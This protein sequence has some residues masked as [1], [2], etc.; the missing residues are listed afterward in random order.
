[1]RR[2]I[3]VILSLMTLMSWACHEKIIVHPPPRMPEASSPQTAAV[4]PSKPSIPSSLDP[5]SPVKSIPPLTRLDIGDLYFRQGKYPR[6]IQE[7][8]AGLK[9]NPQSESKDRIL[10][11]IGLSY[12][13]SSR[14]DRNLSGAKTTLK[15]LITEFSGSLYKSQAELILGLIAQVEQLNL[16]VKTRDSKIDR[17]QEELN[18]LKEI[19]MKRRP[20]RPSD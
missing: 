4:T 17:L 3:S 20:S 6:A 11:N 2:V 18:R 15:K 14:S 8:E 13:L 1:M 19:D 7:Y 12:A 5:A 9:S 10:F 16:D